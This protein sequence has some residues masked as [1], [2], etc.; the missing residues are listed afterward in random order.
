MVPEKALVHFLS[1][2]LM[3]RWKDRY[4]SLVQTKHGKQKFLEDLW[5]QIED[6][7]DLAKSV[8]DFNRNVWGSPAFSF[9][10]NNGFGQIEESMQAAFDTVGDGSL[11]IDKEGKYGIYL[12]EDKAEKV[13]YFCV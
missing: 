13:K 12:P 3:K 6:R 10:Q 8:P 1:K 7:F 5:H 11:I 4:I 2:A 9:S